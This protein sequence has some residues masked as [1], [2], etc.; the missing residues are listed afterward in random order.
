MSDPPRCRL[1]H[2]RSLRIQALENRLALD[3]TPIPLGNGEEIVGTVDAIAGDQEDVYTFNADAGDYIVVGA[4]RDHSATGTVD[5]DVVSPT[6]TTHSRSGAGVV[7]N[8]VADTSGEYRILVREW[9]SDSALAY[10][11]RRIV[12]SESIDFLY[13]DDAVLASGEEHSAEVSP[14]EFSVVQFPATADGLIYPALSQ[15]AGD[16][17]VVIS[18][19]DG[20]VLAQQRTSPPPFEAPITGTY[21][22]VI[23]EWGANVTLEFSFTV[24][25]IPGAVDYSID[26]NEYLESGEQRIAEVGIDRLD[27]IQF[28]ADTGDSILATLGELPS[29][30][31]HRPQLLIADPQGNVLF[32]AR[33][34]KL[35]HATVTAT[36]TGLYTAIVNTDPIVLT[37]D[38]DALS[39]AFSIA[40]LPSAV[41]YSL[42]QNTFL[43]SGE[44]SVLPG[45]IG[46][47]HLFQFD[48]TA[49][50]KIFATLSPTQPANNTINRLRVFDPQGVLVSDQSDTK[51]IGLVQNT[52]T[53]GLHTAV[54]TLSG[55]SNSPLVFRLATLPNVLDYS[56]PH[57]TYLE[58]GQTHTATLAL[59]GLDVVQFHAAEGE[60]VSATLSE[61]ILADP[62]RPQM[63]IVDPDGRVVFG[64]GD[65]S[66]VVSTFTAGVSG[67]YSAVMTESGNDQLIDYHF[68]LATTTEALPGDFDADGDIGGSDFLVWQ[69]ELG[70]NTT[71]NDLDIWQDSYGQPSPELA[72][73]H[74]ES[75]L[76]DRPVMLDES[77]FGEVGIL[78]LMDDSDEDEPQSPEQLISLEDRDL[79]FA[80]ASSAPST[81]AGTKRTFTSD[82]ADESDA[83]LNV[84]LQWLTNELLEEV[85]G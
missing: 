44:Q 66:T 41:D 33:D 7:H 23:F 30:G 29:V 21:T 27:V 11:V 68:S 18:A 9:K 84:E 48:A 57:N 47:Q 43:E 71:P 78:G 62:A 58:F 16:R 31:A 15:L 85:A 72:A 28:H 75:P 13:E 61:T 80:T 25:S 52:A 81:L 79:I 60:T 22:A 51:G 38:E 40:I 64:G 6:G 35:V 36:T 50:N 37:S 65:S 76:T 26:R 54:V 70:L 42:P 2:V 34:D 82:E 55:K 63:R 10:R 4:Y 77:L 67:L 49:G 73:A 32:D 12:L 14:G 69:R 8:F 5:L 59:G 39:Y 24:A 19:P 1:L 74:S 56:L 20:Q 53:S 3:G 17:F 46:T 83:E 45:G